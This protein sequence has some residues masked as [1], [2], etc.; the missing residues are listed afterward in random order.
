MIAYTTRIQQSSINDKIIAKESVGAEMIRYTTLDQMRWAELALSESVKEYDEAIA[1]LN[2]AIAMI[3]QLKR[4]EVT[5]DAPF[6]Q[7]Q[8][9]PKSK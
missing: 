4:F 2:K 5:E 8:R 9:K 6:K 1:H 7:R 3:T